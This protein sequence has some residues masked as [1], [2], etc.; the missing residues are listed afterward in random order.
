MNERYQNN[1]NRLAI[2]E[3]KQLLIK[4]LNTNSAEKASLIKKLENIL[5]EYLGRKEDS[6]TEMQNDSFSELLMDM[7]YYQPNPI[8]RLSD[9][10][11]IDDNKLN[12]IIIK[13]LERVQ[14]FES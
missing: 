14:Q 6:F 4:I 5:N 13:F 1:G 3:L 8:I 12:K 2:Y 7:A 11:L 9:K 10:N